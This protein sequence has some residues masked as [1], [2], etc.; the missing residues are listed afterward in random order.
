MV[1]LTPS[2]FIVPVLEEYRTFKLV[3]FLFVKKAEN[4]LNSSGCSRHKQTYTL[5]QPLTNLYNKITK[6]CSYKV[7]AIKKLKFMFY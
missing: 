3:G 4:V 2:S 7:P 6:L 5:K 1:T